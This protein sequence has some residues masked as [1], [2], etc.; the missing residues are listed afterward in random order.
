MLRSPER[1]PR[2]LHTLALF[3]RLG[4]TAEAKLLFEHPD[5][6]CSSAKVMKDAPSKLAPGGTPSQLA[7][8]P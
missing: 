1:G 5:I 4:T 8:L 3:R 2:V 6:H 7:S